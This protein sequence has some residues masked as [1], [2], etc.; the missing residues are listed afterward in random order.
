M[1]RK[2]TPGRASTTQTQQLPACERTPLLR[3]LLRRRGWRR[4]QPARHAGWLAGGRL[5]PGPVVFR[6]APGRRPGSGG[7]PCLR[8]GRSL[9]RARRPV[10]QPGVPYLCV[11]CVA[12][13][14]AGG[15]LARAASV[16]KRAREEV[17]G[18]PLPNATPSPGLSAQTGARTA[19]SYSPVTMRWGDSAED[20]A[21]EPMEVQVQHALPE[22]QVR[23]RRFPGSEREAGSTA[24]P[25][26][27]LPPRRP[28]V[29]AA[30][31]DQP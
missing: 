3:R 23:S 29:R 10:L 28:A 16:A 22:T 2:Q 17:R 25:P 5:S 15:G 1:G 30:G 4:A 11:V 31:G 20:D 7:K 27:R 26:W 14:D 13:P 24:A 9:T 19:G 12:A 6:R 21:A 8:C 18:E